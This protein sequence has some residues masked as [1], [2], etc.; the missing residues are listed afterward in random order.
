MNEVAYSGYPL[1][2]QKSYNQYPFT[3]WEAVGSA[4]GTHKNTGVYTTMPEEQA[5]KLFLDDW[6]FR[7]DLGRTTAKDLNVSININSLHG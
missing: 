7:H 2:E 3:R 4:N 5:Y 6:N 1:M